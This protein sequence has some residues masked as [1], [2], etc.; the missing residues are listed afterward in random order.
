MKRVSFVMKDGVVYKR[1]GNA[2]IFEGQANAPG[3]ASAAA[4]F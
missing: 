4:D 2:L 3:P 1:G